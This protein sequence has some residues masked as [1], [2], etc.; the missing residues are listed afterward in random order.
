M[1]RVAELQE[2]LVCDEQRKLLSVW[3]G[4]RESNGLVPRVRLS[5]GA[6]VEC[7]SRTSLLQWS[8]EGWRVRLA[9]SE[10]FSAYGREPRGLTLDNLAA[11][12]D[13]Q[14]FIDTLRGPPD[15]EPRAGLRCVGR[16]LVHAWIRLPVTSDG[17]RADMLLTHDRWLQAA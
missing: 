4:L 13:D 17:Q 12:A 15:G 5:P 3:A 11:G 8:E 7:L 16:N 14:G 9:G 6:F 2:R 10:L 1:Y